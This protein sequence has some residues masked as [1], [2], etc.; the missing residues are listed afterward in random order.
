[1]PACPNFETASESCLLG[2]LGADAVGIS[3]VSE[4]NV[5]RHCGLQ[6]FG[7]S[8]ITIKV[9]MD[10]GLEKANHK[11][12]LEARKAAAQK[13]EQFVSILIESIPPPEHVPAVW[14]WRALVHP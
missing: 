1:M 3:T 5:A 10:Y 2:M 12:V 13:L 4:V 7:F 9:V 8:L 11:E 14:P 6:V